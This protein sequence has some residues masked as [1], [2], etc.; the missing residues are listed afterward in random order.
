MGYAKSFRLYKEVKIEG[1]NHLI[2]PRGTAKSFGNII[3]VRDGLLEAPAVNFAFE[4]ELFENQI[5][6]C[7]YL[8]QN[9]L[10]GPHGC[11]TLNMGAGL[12]KTAT[13]AGIIHRRGV[14]TLYITKDRFLQKQAYDDLKSFF[15]HARIA[16]FDNSKY[17]P[18]APPYDI[19]IMVVNSAMLQPRSFY[20]KFGLIIV[21]EIHAYCGKQRA[22]LFWN[23]QSRYLLGMS[24][25]TNDRTDALDVIYHRH[26][27][28]VVH[29]SSL[30][31]FNIAGAE[32]QGK[33][34]II[35]YKGEDRYAKD[36]YNETTGM[37]FVPAMIALMVQD[38]KRNR[39]VVREI[40]KL[41]RK[42][43][44][45][46]YV[47][48]EYRDHLETLR[49]ML[50]KQMAQEVLK[51]VMNAV[52]NQSREPG[53]LKR[54]VEEEAAKAEAE[55]VLDDGE[56]CN[57]LM[58]GVKDEDIKQ[59]VK[60]RVILTTYGYGSTGISIKHMNSAVF[61]TPRRNG[62]KQ[63]LARAMRRGSDPAIVRKFVDIVDQKT[64]I[65]YQLY[66][67]KQAY[68]Y[69]GF[70]TKTVNIDHNQL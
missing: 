17:D 22:E 6:V 53:D 2:F 27:G 40:M 57:K 68:D 47:F 19:T 64:A 31:G 59:A 63:T 3:G 33:V 56:T 52:E 34:K 60:G 36:I 7:D 30:P 1:K 44:R 66:G 29:A 55:L 9:Y 37:L 49:T 12:G 35:K 14:R 62:Y 4:G 24:A 45:Y 28:D 26:F 51:R 18:E 48:S 20:A 65:K 10:G 32:F 50:K 39:L 15:P 67:R 23:L 21:D 8:M 54:I 42:P 5:V 13:S 41:W 46:I 61:A 70:S 11:C 69:Y 58:G 43:N 16:K 38:E 25:T